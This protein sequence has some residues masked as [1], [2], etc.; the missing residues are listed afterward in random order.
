MEGDQIIKQEHEP[1]ALVPFDNEEAIGVSFTLQQ[2]NFCVKE[3]DCTVE[4]GSSYLNEQFESSVEVNDSKGVM[5][6]QVSD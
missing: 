4:I 5:I 2:S 6:S 3:S 1:V